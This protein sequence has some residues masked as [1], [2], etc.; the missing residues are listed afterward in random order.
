MHYRSHDQVGLHPGGFTSRGGVCIG[1]GVCIQG[2][3]SRPPN[4]ILRN[5]VNK[6]A[7]H[8]LLECILVLCF[9]ILPSILIWGG[10]FSLI[11]SAGFSISL[12][13]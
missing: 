12:N 9:N 8:I 10:K 11:L 1:G 4:W 7:V 3:L 5:T 6:W 13:M 2:C